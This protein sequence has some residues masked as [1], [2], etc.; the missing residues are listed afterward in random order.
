MSAASLADPMAIQLIVDR[1]A[2]SL[3]NQDPQLAVAVLPALTE[4]Y[5]ELFGAV[6]I[7]PVNRLFYAVWWPSASSWP[8]RP[9]RNSFDP[10]QA[11]AGAPA[12]AV[13]AIASSQSTCD[14]THL[15]HSLAREHVSYMY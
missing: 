1:S 8:S 5:P 4:H 9:R 2:S 7:A 10:R 13:A 6:Y 12:E 14:L 11:L 15:A 3:A